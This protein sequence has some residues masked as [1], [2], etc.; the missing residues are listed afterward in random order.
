MTFKNFTRPIKS[1]I[2]GLD[3]HECF[4]IG[5]NNISWL[6]IEEIDVLELKSF[7]LVFEENIST[8]YIKI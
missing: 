1:R 5:A 7:L 3:I 4:H 6:I 8:F 2:K